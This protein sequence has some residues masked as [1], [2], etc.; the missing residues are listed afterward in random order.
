MKLYYHDVS[1]TSRPILLLAAD[2]GITLT[3]ECVDLFT[4]ANLL[5]IFTAINPNQQVPMLDDD[6]FLLTESSV[7]LKYLAD[8]TGS[9]AYPK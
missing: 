1:T 9:S 2:E 6:G 8:K 7:I 3:L 4:G 5:P